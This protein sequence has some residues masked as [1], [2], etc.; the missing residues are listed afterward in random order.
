LSPL[1][2]DHLV[3]Y[4]ASFLAVWRSRS[5]MSTSTWTIVKTI[6]IT[7]NLLSASVTWLCLLSLCYHTKTY[8]TKN[9]HHWVCCYNKFF[10]IFNKTSTTLSL[11]IMNLGPNIYTLYSFEFNTIT[12]IF[13]SWVDFFFLTSFN[14]QLL[15]ETKCFFCINTLI[16]ALPETSICTSNGF[17]KSSSHRIRSYVIV[18]FSFL[19][20]HWQ[21]T[22]HSHFWLFF[23]RSE[24]GDVKRFERKDIFIVNQ[25][26]QLLP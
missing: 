10:Y 22:N 19:K 11:L 21:S 1:L 13:F 2:Q 6:T 18:V 4:A 8:S 3:F 7:S 9:F 17:L 12:V 5:N 24:R 25:L 15:K 20:A 26:S 14:F 16:I 23:K